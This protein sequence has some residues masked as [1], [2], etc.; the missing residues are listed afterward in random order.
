MNATSTKGNCLPSVSSFFL[1][2]GSGAGGLALIDPTGPGRGYERA[3]CHPSA[4][5][6]APLRPAVTRAEER[7]AF[8]CWAGG[9]NACLG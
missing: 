2:C 3:Q 7:Q 1:E 8:F 4:E 5:D 9:R 6:P